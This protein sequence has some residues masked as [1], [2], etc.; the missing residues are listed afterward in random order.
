MT[1]DSNTY[2]LNPAVLPHFLLPS[3][4]ETFSEVTGFFFTWLSYQVLTPAFPQ[5]GFQHSADGY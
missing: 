5:V 4:V 2:S 3:E 1:N